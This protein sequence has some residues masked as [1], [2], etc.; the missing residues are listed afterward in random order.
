M[1]RT[2]GS[3][4]WRS[5]QVWRFRCK[6]SSVSCTTS[7]T[8]SVPTP[9]REKPR[10]TNPR[11][12]G[13]SP[14]STRRYA[15]ASPR[16]AARISSV[17]CESRPP[18]GNCPLYARTGCNVTACLSNHRRVSRHGP[19]HNAVMTVTAREPGRIAT[20]SNTCRRIGRRLARHNCRRH[21]PVTDV[22]PRAVLPNR[23]KRPVRT[24]A[25]KGTRDH[26]FRGCRDFLQDAGRRPL[27]DETSPPLRPEECGALSAC[28]IRDLAATIH[29]LSLDGCAAPYAVYTPAGTEDAL[30]AL[31]PASFRLLL[32]CDDDFGAR[33]LRATA[34][35]LDAGHAGAILVNADSPTL[36]ASILRAAVDR[37]PQRGR[38]RA[39]PG[40]RRRLHAHRPV[41]AAR[42]RVRGHPLEHAASSSP[43]VQRA[44]E[45]GLPVV[46]VPRWYDVDDSQ[47][48]RLLEA[49]LAGERLPFAEPG[50][51][52]AEAP[53][54][55]RFL[56]PAPC[57]A[58]G[59][60]RDGNGRTHHGRRLR[61]GSSRRCL[62]SAPWASSWWRLSPPDR[63]SSAR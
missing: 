55:R 53:A 5:S 42:A 35:L 56:E 52:G 14:S 8:S 17:S 22:T 51:E 21:V 6:A 30:R 60:R 37:R 49:E 16:L 18:R 46:N 59:R 32:Q 4:G 20:A 44:A 1:A 23:W 39:R 3:N 40:D 50:I 54:T 38:G 34:D 25:T 12:I 11:R 9:Y 62:R 58:A 15:S 27:Q 47:T 26:A 28:F 61:H 41:A 13:A 57:A 2:Q 7:S 48:L 19:K 24:P 45:I 33:L 36:P 29:S 43:H 63:G 31:L 10:F